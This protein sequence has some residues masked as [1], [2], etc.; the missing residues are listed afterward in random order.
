MTMLF[1]IYLKELKDC[2]RDR[3]TLLLTVVL[4]IVLMTCFVF[5]LEQFASHG[6]NEVYTV[7]VKQPFDEADRDIF[8]NYKNLEFIEVNDPKSAVIDGRAI[9]GLEFSRSVTEVEKSN[10]TMEITIIGD[11]LS[12]NS[13]IVMSNIESA[14][15]DYEKTIISER[16]QQLQIDASIME[17]FSIAYEETIEGDFSLAMIAYLIPLILAVAVGMGAGP[18]AGDLFAGEKERKTMEAILMTPVKRSTLLMAKWLTTTTIASLTGIITLIVVVS[19]I[20]LFTTD[21]K[22]AISLGEATYIVLITAILTAVVYASVCASFLMLTSILA[23][24]VKEAQTYS[25]PFLMLV[26]LPAMYIMGLGI[27]ELEIVHFAIPIVNLFT[28]FK[29]LLFGI[30]QF[31]HIAITFISNLTL[32]LIIFIIC[33]ILF[34]KDRWVMNS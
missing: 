4:P 23:K 34:M 7:A 15:S 17:P 29:E 20:V 16:L 31:D 8:A 10:D 27:N 1:N 3:R 9:I 2:F 6:K 25:T 21:L 32:T 14:L 5:V 33:R 22:A 28:I 18:S 19:E 26:I 13:G 30:V 11:V 24:T 12:Q